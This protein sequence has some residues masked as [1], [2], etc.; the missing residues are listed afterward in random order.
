MRASVTRGRSVGCAAQAAG[1]QGTD[2]RACGWRAQR[3]CRSPHDT[4]TTT[5]PLAVLATWVEHHANP[6]S[7]PG[8]DFM[9]LNKRATISKMVTAKDVTAFRKVNSS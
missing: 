9:A 3:Q 7:V 1:G 4:L 8:R 5:L 2:G 6:D